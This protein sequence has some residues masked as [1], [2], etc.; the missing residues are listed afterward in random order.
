M[1]LSG[2]ATEA[3]R[4]VE[5]PESPAELADRMIEPLPERAELAPDDEDMPTSCSIAQI[6]RAPLSSPGALVRPPIE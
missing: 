6:E 1:A 4:L 2:S 3:A 5:A